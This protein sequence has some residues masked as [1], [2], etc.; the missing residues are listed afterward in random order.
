MSLRKKWLTGLF[1]GMMAVGLS[2][3]AA[4]AANPLT[5]AIHNQAIKDGDGNAVQVNGGIVEGLYTR[6][7]LFDKPAV[8]GEE[9]GM[10]VRAS[11]PKDG[12]DLSG[13]QFVWNFVEKQPGT[14]F[15]EDNSKNI[16]I[17]FAPAGNSTGGI[18][19]TN[20][21]EG[22]N[23]TIGGYVE[24]EPIPVNLFDGQW[25]AIAGKLD[26]NADGS[27][28]FRVTIDGQEFYNAPLP[29]EDAN[30]KVADY[31]SNGVVSVYSKENYKLEFKALEEAAAPAAPQQGQAGAA[32]DQPAPA[33]NPKT[34][35]AS[36]MAYVWLALA[37]LGAVAFIKRRDGFV[38]EQ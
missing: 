30:F 2:A 17:Q 24:I 21:R 37:A 5:E 33:A 6:Y 38:R 29:V 16:N 9:A 26:V 22:A 20:Y 8:F 7:I 14:V 3:S 28:V 13:W 12:A 23:A 4:M 1:A 36:I 27:N 34:G 35:D 19:D 25:H 31:F 15:W 18:I 32:E 10:M 11:E